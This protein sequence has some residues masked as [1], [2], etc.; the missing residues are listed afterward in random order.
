[1]G[2]KSRTLPLRQ[3][4]Q[5]AAEFTQAAFFVPSARPPQ[6]EVMWTKP[7]GDIIYKILIEG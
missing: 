5:K 3:R 4:A 7:V 1:M 2:R 6:P